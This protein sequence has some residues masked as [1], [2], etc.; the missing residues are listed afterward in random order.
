MNARMQNEGYD[1][2]FREQVTKS[3][4]KKYKDIISKDKSGECPLYR[5]KEWKKAEG[6]K[7]ETTKQNRMV[8]KG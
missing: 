3:A 2:K 7:K 6:I 4:L 1:I 8:Q 5:N